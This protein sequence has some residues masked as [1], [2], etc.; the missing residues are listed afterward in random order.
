MENKLSFEELYNFYMLCLKNKKKKKG[1]YSFVN[2]SLC[3]N[4]INLLDELNNRTYMPKISNCYIITE[5]A[6]REIYAAQFLDR[7]V[8]HFYMSEIEN[9]LEEELVDGCCS[10]RK[11]KGSDYALNLLKESIIK[12]SNKGKEDCYYL[13]IDLSGYF[14]SIDRKQ[15]GKKFEKLIL[16]KYKGEHKDLLLYL[17]P[18]IFENNPAQKCKYKCNEKMRAKVPERRRMD[19]KSEYGMA[20]GNLTSQA[21]SNLNLND[22]DNY[23]VNVLGLKDY[24]RYVDDII[25]ISKDKRKLEESLP[26]INNKLKETHQVTN[27]KKTRIDTVYHGVPFLGKISYPY[28]YQ[29]ANKRV[30]IRICNKARTIRY[31]NQKNLIAKVNAQIGFLKNYNCRKL[32]VN[33]TNL[34]P[35]NIKTFINFDKERYKF[36]LH[37]V[38]SIKKD[39]GEE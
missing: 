22:F 34:L 20:I 26:F 27:K 6:L 24:I 38:S 29:K 32:V 30:S 5:P 25:I 3:Q 36:T 7:V 28:G 33:Y 8:Q 37:Y 19:S 10:C 4:L 13:K 39:N 11:W 18:I 2:E 23:V 12:N 14:M 16:Q 31:D 17:T 15:V 35:D 21:A 9:I 1:T